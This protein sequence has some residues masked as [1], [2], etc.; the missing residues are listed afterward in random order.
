M[1]RSRRSSPWPAAR[2][3]EIKEIGS[4]KLGPAL[5]GEFFELL[6]HAQV[7]A[8]ESLSSRLLAE[9]P[10]GAFVR[11]LA[12]G[13]GGAPGTGSIYHS[14]GSVRRAKVV[15]SANSSLS[16]DAKAVT[17]GWITVF[18]SSGRSLVS[19]AS[20]G[21][22]PSSRA[23]RSATMRAAQG[24]ARRREIAAEVEDD[25]RHQSRS[26]RTCLVHMDEAQQ[27]V[28]AGK[29]RAVREA[30]D[31]TPEQ[32][33]EAI[34]EARSAGVGSSEVSMA[35]LRLLQMK[36]H[37]EHAA[38]RAQLSAALESLDLPELRA[39][40]ARADAAGVPKAEVQHARSVLQNE[41][42]KQAM[43]D[44]LRLIGAVDKGNM[45]AVRELLQEAAGA[46]IADSDEYARVCA[47]LRTAE[48][49][50]AVLT[51]IR[52]VMESSKH[53]T[54]TSPLEDLQH[55]KQLL[56]AMITDAI[57]AGVSEQVL[58]EVERRRKLI[59]N[60]ILDMKGSV[61]VFCRVRP[62]NE[63][64]K[65]EKERD[66]LVKMDDMHIAVEIHGYAYSAGA[67]EKE[68][69]SFDSVFFPGK[70][71]EV[72]E[73]CRDLVR[74]V[75]D[76][77]N[78]TIF[79]YGQTGAG[80]THT[81]YGSK[82]S[83][84]IA[85]RTIREIF[86]NLEAESGRYSHTVVGSM[87]EVYRNEFIE[88][89]PADEPGGGDS[90]HSSRSHA[91]AAS[92]RPRLSTSTTR[93]VSSDGSRHSE[94]F[95]QHEC[96]DAAAMLKLLEEGANR[97]HVNATAMNSCSSRS[98]LILTVSVTRTN[99]ETGDK[100]VG[101]IMLCDLAGSE[102]LKKSL[103]TGD[104]AKEAIEIN[105]SLQA[106]AEVLNALTTGSKHVPYHNSKLTHILRD[107]L[108]GSSK[109]LMFVNC[110]PAGSSC[111]ESRST[112]HYAKR[113]KKVVNH[114]QHSHRST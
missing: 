19:R 41:D 45:S 49:T 4:L 62:R 82:E 61:R 63:K 58:K 72:F 34:K 101:K 113:A 54:G 76:G 11:M 74:S 68:V 64:E 104:V 27:A 30:D 36:D 91:S 56:S 3:S 77:Y 5:V 53:L 13:G 31:A 92:A 35:E 67:K 94:S 108:G 109:T 78:V 99:K 33:A 60:A 2:A 39:A 93:R 26:R 25:D 114:Q 29:L 111:E 23:D 103:V 1:A 50:E 95:N 90:P 70:Q 14:D 75:L 22:A 38:A 97:R 16:G 42:R 110:S 112:L 9:L 85:P 24:E 28:A 7:R 79:S 66:C 44:R 32:L 59:H 55:S 12:L 100:V 51:K 18:T 96:S 106:L 52:D 17:C 20:F 47:D 98:H 21:L 83:E 81:M 87:F 57:E 84:G 89:L 46:G 10:R 71:E 48:A 37:A 102:R 6:V 65:A 40:V 107:A 80:K 69:F 15:A 43:L 86:D 105:K 8:G 73:D 88:L